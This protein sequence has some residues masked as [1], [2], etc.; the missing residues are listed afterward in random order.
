MA[1]RVNRATK[2]IGVSRMPRA[3]LTR[4]PSPRSA[5]TNSP[6]TAPMTA[7]VTP[8][9]R[10]PNQHGQRRGHFEHRERLPAAGLERAHQR[11]Q[12]GLDR[13]DADDRGDQRGKEDGQR[14]HQHLRQ[15]AEAEPD[16]QQRGQ[17]DDGHR[18]RGDDVGREDALQQRRLRQQIAADG[19]HR[20]AQAPG[21]PD[22]DQ[23]GRRCAC[24]RVPS[25][26]QRQEARPD[27]TRAGQDERRRSPASGP[28][29]PSPAGTRPAPAGSAQGRCG[30]T[31]C[32]RVRA[33]ARDL[34]RSYE[35]QSPNKKPQGRFTLGQSNA[36][37]GRPAQ[38]AAALT[39]SHPDY[40][41]GPG[42]S[43][44]LSPQRWGTRGLGPASR[45]IPP[46][47]N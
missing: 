9:F 34:G 43:P 11:T 29:A 38:P 7:R 45:T 33:L 37:R 26:S 20:H 27:Q 10:P 39:F 12:V 19:R 44:G 16:D 3:R 25:R 30:T 22:F 28:G 8:T 46:V 41:V 6:T 4:K 36:Y 24:A 5:P 17:R 14:A 47:E 40:T 13:A 2:S 23:G 18:L 35:R 21:R 1:T 32:R 31:V 15:P 42:I